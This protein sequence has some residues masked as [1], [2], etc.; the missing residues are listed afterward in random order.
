MNQMHNSKWK[1]DRFAPPSRDSQVDRNAVIG[2]SAGGA[3]EVFLVT[4]AAGLL[5]GAVVRRLLGAYPTGRIVAV[6]RGRSVPP[7]LKKL[8]SGENTAAR[9][10]IIHGD[11]SKPHV[12]GRLPDTITRVFHLAA[13]IEHDAEQTRKAEIVR[14]NLGPIAHLVEWAQQAPCL[15]QVVY[16]SS[17]SVYGNTTEMVTESS[18]PEPANLYAAAKLAGEDLLGVLTTRG[19]CATCLRFSSL[20]GSEMR[21]ATVLPLM[22]R[23]ARER[24][25]ITVFGSG[26]RVQDFLYVDDAAQA[27]LLACRHAAA[28]I[29][30]AAAG[31]S[32]T[33]AVLA[34]TV[35][36]VVAPGRA[37]VRI[38][39]A[40]PEGSPGYV[41][42]VRKAHHVLGFF[43]RYDLETG[44][45]EMERQSGVAQPCV[46]SLS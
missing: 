38:E 30:N 28:G 21:A 20:Y 1:H 31:T 9:L 13:R 41:V 36:N 34:Q 46:P 7:R 40:R 42:D 35:A 24:G 16:A 29:F 19:L 26:R 32:V 2:R 22:I 27:A 25:E 45:R 33:M 6:V 12:W 5:G 8:S 15:R 14:D 44:L 23:Q 37:R 18:P 3:G 43:P 4:G 10:A 11:L 17:V 39:T